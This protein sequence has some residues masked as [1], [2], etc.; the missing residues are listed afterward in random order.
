MNFIDTHAH[1]Y[2]EQFD[3]DREAMVHRA[4]A[5]GIEQIFLPNIDSRTVSSM[6]ELEQSF[7]TH[8]FAM[9]GL[10]PC[11]RSLLGQDLCRGAKRCLFATMCDGSGL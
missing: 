8:C 3:Q 7:P 4:I 10:H 6:L 11:S 9:M 1:L 5:S 2:V